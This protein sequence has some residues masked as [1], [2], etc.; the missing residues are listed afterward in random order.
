MVVKNLVSYKKRK[1]ELDFERNERNQKRID[2]QR[3]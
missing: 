2:A 1:E 3:V